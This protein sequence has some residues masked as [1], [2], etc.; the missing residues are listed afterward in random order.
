MRHM[1]VRCARQAC[2]RRPCVAWPL[3]VSR[4][5]RHARPPWRGSAYA[6]PVPAPADAACSIASGRMHWGYCCQSFV[7]SLR[8]S[9]HP[10]DRRNVNRSLD[11]TDD[12]EATRR[13]ACRTVLSQPF[14]PKSFGISSRLVVPALHT[15]HGLMAK[16][17]THHRMFHHVTLF[18]T[19]ATH[20]RHDERATRMMHACYMDTGAF[21]FI[22]GRPWLMGMAGCLR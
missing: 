17:P 14:A 6:P 2:A 12:A 19:T 3:P 21:C 7:P 15:G 20:T 16:L 8:P 1:C 10:L 13:P 18:V 11:R 4:A 9:I 22:H 5:R